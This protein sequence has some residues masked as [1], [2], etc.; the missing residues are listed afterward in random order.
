MDCSLFHDRL[1]IECNQ[2]YLSQ[3]CLLELSNIYR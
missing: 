2:L 1:F 3:V